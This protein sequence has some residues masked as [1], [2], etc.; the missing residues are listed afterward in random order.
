[1]EFLSPDSKLMRGLSDLVDAIWIN[2]LMLITCIPIITIGAALTAA[3]VASRRSLQGQGKVTV[4]Y[5]RAFKENFF[6]S[7]LLWFVFGPL[8]AVLVAS[9]IFLQ[10]TP[11]L[12]PKFG[13]SIVWLVA[14]DWVWP[15]QARFTNSVGRTLLNS[16]V[17]GFA[18]L[19]ETAAMVLID[20]VYFGLV[21]ASWF[22]MPQGLILLLILGFGVITM[23]HVLLTEKVFV[24]YVQA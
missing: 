12:I 9:W 22:F 17:F 18:Y 3:H 8:L 21:A 1:M 4:N 24:K 14:F 23:L 5:F 16:L 11:L 19:G 7:T 10:I 15:L 20:V 2:V 13:L 6:Q